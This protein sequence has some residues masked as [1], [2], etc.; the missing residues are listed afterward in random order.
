VRRA[1]LIEVRRHIASAQLHDV[2]SR[3]RVGSGESGL[4]WRLQ[5][6]RIPARLSGSVELGRSSQRSRHGR[7]RC[8]A[9]P[10][11]EKCSPVSAR[12]PHD[13]LALTTFL[14]DTNIAA[15]KVEM[16]RI[17]RSR[18]LPNCCQE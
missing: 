8:P 18:L 5:D 13:E 15:L 11:E 2:S 3:V 16:L 12:Y 1:D 6:G 9:F 10:R 14:G 7:N 17:R 4:M